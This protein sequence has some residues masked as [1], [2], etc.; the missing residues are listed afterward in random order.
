M[1]SYN[2]N[3]GT[4]RNDHFG[5][6]T[7]RGELLPKL[8]AT[9]YAGVTYRDPGGSVYVQSEDDT[10]F[11]FNATL[12]YALT[13][14]IGLFAKG[15]RDFGNAAN[16]QSSINTSGEF[17]I[18]YRPFE[19]IVTTASFVYLNTQY[20]MNLG[21][22]DRDDDT[23]IA[24]AGISYLPNKFI[25]V[26]ANYRYFANSSNVA[27]ATYNQHLVDITFAVKY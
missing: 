20:Q 10:T 17:G 1:A 15:A 3:Y 12:G 6:L 11:A 9:V 25:T 13:E 18:N 27:Y 4:N 26:S 24:R 19:Q 7:V 21:G 8:T 5:G 2:A 23:Y 16:R 22:L 14:K